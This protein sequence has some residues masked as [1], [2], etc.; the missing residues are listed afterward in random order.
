MW[1]LEAGELLS[2]K[3]M[4]TYHPAFETPLATDGTYAMVRSLFPNADPGLPYGSNVTS[5]GSCSSRNDEGTLRPA[6][7]TLSELLQNI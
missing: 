2:A 6:S 1:I 3:Q 5:R 7:K 4:N